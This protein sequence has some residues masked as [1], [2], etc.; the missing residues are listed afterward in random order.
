MVKIS[1]NLYELKDSLK[2][3]K[4][5]EN[6]HTPKSLTLKIHH[7]G[8]FTPIPSR[9]YVGGQV[10]SVNVDD[11]D[12]FCL[13]GLDYGM[14]SLNVDADVLEMAKYVKD[15]KIILVYVEHGSSIFV[16]PKKEVAIA[17]DNHLR[18]GPTEIDSS[19]GPA[20]YVE[21]PI[22]VECADDPFKDLDEILEGDY[23]SGSD[24]E[25]LVYDRKH[26]E[27]FDDDDHIVEDV[28]VSM[29]NYSFIAD[30]KHGLSIGVVEEKANMV[31]N[32][33]ERVR[34]RCEGTI[35]ALVPYVATQ[36]DMGKNKISQTKGGPIIRDNNISGKQNIL[37]K[38]KTYQ[39]KGK[40][41][42]RQKKV[43]KYLCPWT[44]LVAY[45]NKGRWEVKQTLKQT[46][47]KHLKEKESLMKT[48]TL[49]KN[50]FKKEESRNIDREIA[51]EQRIKH[52]DNI[53]F[54]RGFQNPFYLK[55]ARQLKP[56]L[57]DGN[58]IE[59]TNAIV[60]HDTEETL[61]FAE[62]SRSKML[63]KQKDPMMLQ[64]KV[65]I[66]PVDY[67]VLN[68]LSQDFDTRFLPQTKLS[69]EQAFWSWNSVNSREPTPSSRP[70][71]VEVPKSQ[72]KDM[73]IKKLKER[74]I[75]L[76]GNIKDDKIKKK[77]EEIEIINIELDHKVTKLIA[78]N[79]HL[80]QTYK[81][82]YDSIK[83]SRILSKEQRVNMSTS[84]SGS[85]PSGNTKKDK[86]QQTPSST[87]N[88]K[89]EACLRT[90]RS[91]LINK[92]RAVKLKDATYVLHSKLNVNS[93]LKCV[94]CNG[95]QFFDNHDSFV[96]DFINNVNAHVKFKAVMKTL[97]RKVWKP[98][99]N[100]F[101]NIGY[102]WRPTGRTFTIVGNVCPL[103]R[104]TTTA[105]VPLR[106]SIA[107]ESD[108]HKR[109]V[110]LVYSRKPKASKN[111]IP[112]SKS[113]HIKSS[114]ANKKEPNKSWGST[115]SNVP[116]SSIDECRLSK[117]FSG[118]G[119][120]LLSIGQF[121]DSD[122]EVAFRQ[123]TCFIRNLEGANLLTRSQGKNLYTLSLGDMLASSPICL[124]SKASKTKSWLWHRRLSHLNFDNGT[125]F[126]NQTMLE[127][128]EQVGISHETSVAR[129]PQ[130]NGVI[131]RRNRTLIEAASTMLI[132]A[133]AP[134]FLWAEAVATA[135]FTQ[136]RS[137]VRLRH[138]K[139]PYEILH[140]KL[141]DLSFFH[142]FSALCYPT[143]DSENLGKLQSKPD[144]AMASEQ[145]SSGP[146]HHE[147][148]SATISSRLVPNHTSSTPFVP[149]SRTYWDML[150]QPLFDELL[151]PPP[152][153]DHPA[154]EVIALIAKIVASKPAA[155]TGSPSSTIADQ[156]APLPN[157]LTQSYWIEAMQEELNEFE[158]L[159]VWELVPRPDKV[160]VITLN[161]IYK[162]KLDE[163]EGI[164]KN[165]SRQ[166]DG[167]VDKDNPNHVYKLK[168]ALCGLKQ[169]PH[170]WYDMLSSFLISQDFSKGS[171]D[172][173]LFIRRDSKDLLLILPWWTNPNWIRINKGKPLIRHII[174]A[175]PTEKHLHTDK[176]IFRYLIGTVNRG[177][178]EPKDSSIT[179]TSFADTDHADCQDTRRNTFGSMQFL[180]DRLHIDIRYHFIKEHVENGV[181]ELYF[182]KTEY[183]LAGIFTKALG[184]ERIEFLINKLRMRSFTSETLKQLVDEVKE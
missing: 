76:S 44:M 30:P 118:L 73:V 42:N 57:Y 117:L 15:Y 131:E 97:K 127:Y 23:T 80:K 6:G 158:R 60:I 166:L 142:V 136:N 103:T 55:K 78:E 114:S 122:L 143:N 105:E 141:P 88:N 17:V 135:C 110:T 47:L 112:V 71:K 180:G 22:V 81:Q 164:L 150:F 66:T 70:T 43:D 20:S 183:Q 167:F 174:V 98:G 48:V 27:V 163:L 129:S 1:F 56:K 173:T 125:K 144:I 64:K 52:L 63:L 65:N 13:L 121:C 181:I 3:D 170:A 38:D 159:E 25:D 75:S 90:V 79:E 12:K 68:Q 39:M 162:V 91:S 5:A 40:K 74:I 109:V 10:S 120:N 36:T 152:S 46:F 92:N 4:A 24:S 14:H 149:S 139:K 172:P 18:K 140:E 176:R 148:T 26:D 34:V 104:I 160:I 37:G 49:L 128:Y 113:K 32:D 106:K 154:S 111:N 50:D 123:H 100:V 168:K 151:T 77:L 175:R 28:R 62:E 31:K 161:W 132:Y 35:T 89:I 59:K 145:S 130:Q 11:I 8:C 86:I 54:K 126:V 156:D 171:V 16:T 69:V 96:L 33:E 153:V 157:A 29:N 116:S 51:L 169:A 184:R 87:Q 45:T 94:T 101:T 41:V 178:W 67:D 61:M 115:V 7:G 134:L 99:G 21:A 82:L 95:C 2:T 58:V 83:S 119:H 85:Q 93:D 53:V 137:I 84:A 179:L 146:T 107:L 72:E 182:V 102:I 177:L 9:S 147:M 138:G 124:L 108:T 155:S 165:K 133:K 19:P